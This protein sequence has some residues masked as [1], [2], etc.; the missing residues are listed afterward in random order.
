MKEEKEKLYR[1]GNCG[2]WL[3]DPEMY[4]AEEI[5]NAE[6]TYCGRCENE[7]QPR[8]VTRDMAIDAGDLSLEG[9]IY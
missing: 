9:S 8:Y 4:N 5:K 1:C 7:A 6:L 3:G 2:E